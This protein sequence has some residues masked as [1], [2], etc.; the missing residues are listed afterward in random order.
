MLCIA[1]ANRM[2]K[3]EL[4]VQK[5]AEIGSHEIIFFPSDRSTIREVKEKTLLRL[6]TIALEAAEQSFGR[7]I[8]KI[9]H[10]KSIYHIHKYISEKSEHI[11][12]DHN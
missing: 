2:D 10:Q 11:L 6:Q 8:P 1:L 5:L 3:I 4:I 9:T 12:L 7:H